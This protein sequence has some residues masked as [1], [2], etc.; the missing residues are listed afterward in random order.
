MV[1]VSGLLSLYIRKKKPWIQ[2]EHFCYWVLKHIR[3]MKVEVDKELDPLDRVPLLGWELPRARLVSGDL[4]G[5]RSLEGGVGGRRN[6][7]DGL[8]RGRFGAKRLQKPS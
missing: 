4:S 7:M 6:G 1:C 5:L 2:L 3:S 8:E